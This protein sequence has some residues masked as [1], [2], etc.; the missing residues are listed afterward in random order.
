MNQNRIEGVVRGVGGRL[1]D[2]VGGLSGDTSGQARGKVNQVAG[3]AQNAYGKTVD[4]LQELTHDRP[5]VVM[6]S[7]LGAG[8]LFGFALGRR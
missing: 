5:L 7:M 8:L 4:Q 6:L 1:Q 2:A 3:G